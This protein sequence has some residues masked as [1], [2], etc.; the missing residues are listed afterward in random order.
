[1]SPRRRTSPRTPAEKPVDVSE[2]MSISQEEHESEHESEE[3]DE[4]ENDPDS[5]YEEPSQ[6][7]SQ[8]SSLSFDQPS[9]SCGQQI[10][11]RLNRTAARKV[12]ASLFKVPSPFSAHN[13]LFVLNLA[14]AQA[15]EVL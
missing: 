10:R 2:L 3:E 1:M 11:R 14:R 9:P 6:S 15:L 8:S 4:S 5:S 7:S 13:V 12:R